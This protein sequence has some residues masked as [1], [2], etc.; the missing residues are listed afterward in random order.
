MYS[1]FHCHYWKFYIFKPVCRHMHSQ[2]L[3]VQVQPIFAIFTIIKFL[4]SL[5]FLVLSIISHAPFSFP[6]GHS[7]F[8]GR[9][10]DVESTSKFRC[11]FFNAFSTSNK[12]RWNIN[13]ETSTSNRR[14]T[15]KHR[16]LNILTF[17]NAF[18]DVEIAR[19]VCSLNVPPSTPP[20]STLSL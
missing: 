11:W 15:S 9:R 4:F 7:R 13:V 10:F 1:I 16:R 2:A 20:F 5:F 17:S 19:C 8:F 6:S 18:F 14:W 3:A 12:T